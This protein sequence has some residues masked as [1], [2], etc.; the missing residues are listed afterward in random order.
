MLSDTYPKL[1][2]PLLSPFEANE[3]FEWKKCNTTSQCCVCCGDSMEK[4]K[5]GLLMKNAFDG[6]SKSQYLWVHAKCVHLL[7][8]LIQSKAESDRMYLMKNN[9]SNAGC[10]HCG[11]KI[12]KNQIH[13]KLCNASDS[14]RTKKSLWI[15]KNCRFEFAMKIR[16]KLRFP[17]KR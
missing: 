1:N 3:A 5:I 9:G 12:R 13:L 6:G 10:I 14:I 15:H 17:Q 16:E 4:G 8:V 11:T 7:A 2:M